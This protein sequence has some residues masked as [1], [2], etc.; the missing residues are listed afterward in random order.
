MSS[1]MLMRLYASHALTAR[2]WETETLRSPDLETV[3]VEDEH[4]QDQEDPGDAGDLL[5]PIEDG[6]VHLLSSLDDVRGPFNRLRG[7]GLRLF[8]QRAAY[9]A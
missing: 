5:T 3:P 6:E 7:P 1:T 2:I 4:D 8:S 9:T